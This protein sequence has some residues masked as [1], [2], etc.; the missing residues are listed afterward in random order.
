MQKL[1]D[2]GFEK[3]AEVVL[4]RN[5][6]GISSGI[7]IQIDKFEHAK[8]ILYAIIFGESNYDYLAWQVRYIGHTRNSFSNRMSGY[9]R[10]GNTQAVNQRMNSAIREHLEQGATQKVVIYVLTDR[11]AMSI[12]G[13]HLDVAAGLEYSLISY[14][15]SF[16][17]EC[18]HHALENIA[19]NSQYRNVIPENQAPFEEAI[20]DQEAAENANYLGAQN[21]I[22]EAQ[23][24]L[25]TFTFELTEKAY[26]P[27]PVFNVPR[28]CEQFF[29]V[30]GD[31]VDVELV[32]A[33][34][35]VTSTQTT[36]N[37]TANPNHTPRLYFGGEQG[38]T[39]RLWKSSNFHQGD[40]VTVDI[41]GHNH[42]RLH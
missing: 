14:Y 13:L 33:E 11:L 30:Q 19:G 23:P 27:L 28:A 21:Q 41:L 18:N 10:P 6:D 37:R 22:A 15:C 26:W 31:V 8:H 17:L 7:T 24:A 4:S 1:L 35:I 16:N 3:A 40:P 12:Q 20:A 25:T 32:D 42:I 2:L 5:Q 9:Q 29:G 39:Y 34:G 36:I 38:S